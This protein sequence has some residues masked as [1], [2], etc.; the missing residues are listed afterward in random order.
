ML[1]I[2]KES[3][4]QSKVFVVALHGSVLLNEAMPHRW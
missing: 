4:G 2:P 3:D 1:G